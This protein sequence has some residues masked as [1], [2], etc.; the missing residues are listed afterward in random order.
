MKKEELILILKRLYKDYVKK[1]IK[2][3]LLA[4]IL[5]V[6]VAGTTAAT[7][8]LLDP[9]VKKKVVVKIRYKK[10]IKFYFNCFW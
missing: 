7:A 1:R 9:A 3:I 5:S 8:W 10:N 4:L 2:R 6:V